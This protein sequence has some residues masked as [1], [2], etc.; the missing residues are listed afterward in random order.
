MADG[1]AIGLEFPRNWNSIATGKATAWP[2]IEGRTCMAEAGYSEQ[3]ESVTGV[4]L[5]RVL[6]ARSPD[7]WLPEDRARWLDRA[8]DDRPELCGLALIDM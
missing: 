3:L 4:H 1:T 8:G 7:A 5:M 6:V 2:K